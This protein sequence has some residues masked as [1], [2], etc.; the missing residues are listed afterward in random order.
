MQIEG[1]QIT[2]N[3]AQGELRATITAETVIQTITEGSIS[4]LE[5]GMRV[6]I[7]GQR[8]EDGSIVAG[9]ILITPGD[10]SGFFGRGPTED[11]QRQAGQ[12]P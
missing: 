3:T 6:T 1:D 9:S 4:D 11:R 7:I 5:S 12:L 8:S 2:V 10:T